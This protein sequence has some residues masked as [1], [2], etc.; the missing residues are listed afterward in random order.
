MFE[1]APSVLMTVMINLPLLWKP[2]GPLEELKKNLILKTKKKK[3][4]L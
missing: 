4:Y 2:T 3:A 1:K